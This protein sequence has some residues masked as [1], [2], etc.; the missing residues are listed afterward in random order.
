MQMT[1][2]EREEAAARGDALTAAE[3]DAVVHGSEEE[4]QAA[5]DA[6]AARARSVK[7]SKAWPPGG[8][9]TK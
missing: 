2:A 1:P 6:A 3:Y 7:E 4:K 9:E 8:I 5:I